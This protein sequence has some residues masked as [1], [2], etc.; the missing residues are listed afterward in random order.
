MFK[1][2]L[3][4][5][6]SNIDALPDLAK[7]E[8]AL[9]AH[10]F[11]RCEPTQQYS[12]GFISPRGGEFDPLVESFNGEIILKVST[13]R[14]VVPGSAVRQKVDEMAAEIERTQGRKPGRKEKA[15]LKEEALLTLLPRAFSKFSSNFLWIDRKNSLLVLDVGSPRAAE[16]VVGPLVEALATAEVLVQLAPV[17][18][19]LSP[20]AVMADWLST[21]E[22]PEN[23][24]LDREVELKSMDED[25]A[26][27]RYA[28]H[29]L[30]LEEIVNHIAE[31]KR[32][33][34]LAMTWEDRLSFILTDV[35]TVKKVQTLR[36][37]ADMS[38]EEGFDAD[39]AIATG[40][41]REFFPA[42]FA[43]LGGIQELGEEGA[44]AKGAETAQA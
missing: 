3:A 20:G 23:F 1:N 29:N 32:P 18:T 7:L 24:S 39:V 40:E 27:V 28:N 37:S 2:V 5:R 44:P 35:L 19:Q 21:Q 6:I 13:E 22:G 4:Y 15:A 9:K 30:V 42:L 26:T 16:A 14:R 10:V 12:A 41:L 36:A 34:R 11:H 33:T 43:M 25:K 38:T 8:E 17:N 31:G